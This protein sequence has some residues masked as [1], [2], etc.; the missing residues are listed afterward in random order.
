MDKVDEDLTCQFICMEPLVDPVEHLQCENLFCRRCLQQV[1]ATCPVCRIKIDLKQ[2]S[3][4][5][6]RPSRRER[7]KMDDIPVCCLEC[8]TELARGSF[9]NHYHK[10]CPVG[11]PEGCEETMVRF[12]FEAHVAVCKN[13][14]IPCAQGCGENVPRG[15]MEDHQSTSC[16]MPPWLH[17]ATASF[18]CA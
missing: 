8:K 10:L 12:V 7:N 16:K 4:D 3:K 18:Q 13:H 2:D 11:C 15:T 1:D 6:G 17:A 14:E 5:L 9:E